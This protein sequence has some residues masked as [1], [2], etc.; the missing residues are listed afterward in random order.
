MLRPD[1]YHVVSP[2]AVNGADIAVVKFIE[3][4]DRFIWCHARN[5]GVLD[6]WSPWGTVR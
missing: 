5:S 3:G 4:V 2:A 6:T 1:S